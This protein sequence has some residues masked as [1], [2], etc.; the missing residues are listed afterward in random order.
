[1]LSYSKVSILSI[2]GV[3]VVAPNGSYS[4]CVLYCGVVSCAAEME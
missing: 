4:A 3:A 1:M 2:V